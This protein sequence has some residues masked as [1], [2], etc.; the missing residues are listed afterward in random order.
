MRTRS[1]RRAPAPA[2]ALVSP[3]FAGRVGGLLSIFGGTLL[4]IAAS[5]SDGAFEL[6]ATVS[7]GAASV[8]FGLV[9]TRIDWDR[10]SPYAVLVIVPVAIVAL[11]V[12]NGIRPDPYLAGLQY[13]IVGLWVGMSQR[14]GVPALVAVFLGIGYAVPLA[15][16]DPTPSLAVAGPTLALVSAAAGETVAYLAGRLRRAHE[17]ERRRQGR[18]YEALL[19][20]SSDFT[21]LVDADGHV[22]YV[23]RGIERMLGRERRE[24]GPPGALDEHEHDD[25][26]GAGDRTPAEVSLAEMLHPDDLGAALT[27]LAEL[28]AEPGRSIVFRGRMARADGTWAEIEAAGRNLLD[29]P[30]VAGLLFAVRD[31][32][33]RRE[34][35]RELERRATHDELTGLHNRW[36]LFERLS[37]A[38]H[39]TGDLA[40]L[41]CDLDRFKDVNDELG[42]RAG[43]AL[44]REVALRL[45]TVVPD[46]H[47][48]A[49]LG[50]DEFGILLR[51][52]D[53]PMAR[54]VAEEIVAELSRPVVIGHSTVTTSASVGVATATGARS[55]PALDALLADADL[56]MY[57]AKSDVGG[58]RVR[59][60]DAGLRAALL[61]RTQ[62]QRELR[63]GLERDEIVVHYQPIVRLS[64]GRPVGL[65]ALARWQHPERGLLPPG[66]FIGLA[67]QTGL[68]ATLNEQVLARAC[69]DLAELRR[70][71]PRFDAT[72]VSVNMSAVQLSDDRLVELVG[73]NLTAHSL[74]PDRLCLEVTEGEPL[75]GDEVVARMRRLRRIGVR[76][77]VDDFGTGYSSLRYLHKLPLDT[78]KID[79]GFTD[80]VG[81]PEARSLVRSIVE[82]GRGLGMTTVA[83]GVEHPNQV[84][85]LRRLGV[86]LAQGFLYARPVPFGQLPATLAGLADEDRP[87][88]GVP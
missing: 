48:I 6:W 52:V 9:C 78:I 75:V 45:T 42:H 37:Q 82:I 28:A 65:E 18:R 64:D 63:A 66:L 43:D 55:R 13:P 14:S 79:K 16:V 60:Y 33:D 27:E 54:A 62:L 1:A 10:R 34:L 80:G 30:D 2:D 41:Y 77:A 26:P 12:F 83:E 53:E 76:L 44:L 15:I 57:A 56:A 71:S 72:Y 7:V 84:I 5:V 21:V 51:N 31:V 50:G 35:E 70:R 81:G 25:E 69:A 20:Q 36:G 17:K 88:I 4:L 68:V 85:A 40:L 8:L 32:S 22:R 47:T 24:N 49:R 46:G 11:G 61:D 23:S 74:E 39:E 19:A 87:V 73:A 38:H 67:E 58:D 3:G 86:E 29:D 59:S